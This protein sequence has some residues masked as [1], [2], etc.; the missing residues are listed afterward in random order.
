[1]TGT[2][3]IELPSQ[4]EAAIRRC[5]SRAS[6]CGLKLA[7]AESCTGGL[8]ASLLTDIEGSSHVFDRGFVVYSE[9]AKRAMLN[10]PGNLLRDP[11]AVS[12]P[13]AI[14]MAEGAL[15]N[16]RADVAIAI[17]GFAGAAGSGEEEG[18]VHHACARRGGKTLHRETHYGNSGRG[19]I[20]IECMKT[21]VE[22]LER[23]IDQHRRPDDTSLDT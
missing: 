7:V 22:M 2:L 16:S 11:G 18:L 1:M 21:A 19:P 15:A 9:D 12:Q 8:L 6:Q 17:T 14:A 13:V 23:A 10:V 4:L 3:S 20:R 5:L